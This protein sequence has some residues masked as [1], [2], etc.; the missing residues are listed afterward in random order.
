MLI[1]DLND[2]KLKVISH[3]DGAVRDTPDDDYESYLTDLDETKLKF[4]ENVIPT[5]FVMRKLLPHKLSMKI[6]NSMLR[7]SEG[8]MQPQLSMINE[9]VRYSL[10]GIEYPEDIPDNLKANILKYKRSSDGGADPMLIQH[11]DN[12]GIVMELFTARSN[13]IDASGSDPELDKKK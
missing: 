3:K 9:T 6:K 5:R 10:V 13:A 11:L 4:A 8:E 7:F 1:L 2:A 12:A